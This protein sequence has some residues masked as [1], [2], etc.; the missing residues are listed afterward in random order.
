[1]KNLFV[2]AA[3]ALLMLSAYG[4]KIELIPSENTINMNAG[5]TTQTQLTIK[6]NQDK[7]QEVTLI[8]GGYFTAQFSPQDY[9]ILANSQA[10]TTLYIT[11]PAD[12][13]GEYSLTITAGSPDMADA[14]LTD[15]KTITI[16]TAG[17][18]SE[19]KGIHSLI[20]MGQ[21]VYQ[22][23]MDILR[24]PRQQEKRMHLTLTYD[25]VLSNRESLTLKD[26]DD[27]CMGDTI[28]ITTNPSGN[29]FG[30][31]GPTD[32]PAVRFVKD[33]NKG[34]IP[35][36]TKTTQ[37]F[38]PL[39][40]YMA[41]CPERPYNDP[42]SESYKIA[43]KDQKDY[44]YPSI[45]ELC[46]CYTELSVIC[47]TNCSAGSGKPDDPRKFDS[48][49]VTSSGKFEIDVSCEASCVAYY[50]NGTTIPL[51]LNSGT[52]SAVY[53]QRYYLTGVNDSREPRLSVPTYTHNVV[54]GK[55]ELKAGIENKGEVI[56]YLDKVILNKPDAKI[57]YRPASIMPG[58]KE[59]IIVEAG[60]DAADLT[61]S[62][63]FSTEKTGCLKYKD[64]IQTYSIG[65]CNADKDCDDKNPLTT[66]VCMDIG[67]ETS[68]CVNSKYEEI[69]PTKTYQTYAMD[70][71]G[72]CKNRYY[73]CYLPENRDNADLYAGDKCYNTQ[74]SYYTNSLGRFLLRYDLSALSKGMYINHAVLRLQAKS[75]NKPQTIEVYA[76]KDDWEGKTC[77]S[78]GDIC[79]QPYCAECS[80][81]YDIP[82]QRIS[83]QTV[84][85]TT[86]YS[87]DITDYVKDEYSKGT[88]FVS[89]QIRGVEERDTA[90]RYRNGPCKT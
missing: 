75:V 42:N 16:T 47:E 33:L 17:D 29:A 51:T 89:L 34:I 69:R 26:G 15:T 37:E 76:A 32:D 63:S 12:F 13:S 25:P 45:G 74:N 7:D 57:L 28:N 81:P 85:D 40:L 23:K 68:H 53:T 83:S 46:E 31:G 64:F 2:I 22:P 43:D 79:T 6:N 50:P 71:Q 4:S 8:G 30:D 66:D 77:A 41:H 9:T 11:S 14:S 78:G 82:G 39:C 58:A 56:A 65:A 10:E 21:T 3:V 87:F 80:G 62:I 48:L 49:H 18:G 61:V 1:M 60:T 70:V 38:T 35:G 88:R 90:A 54:N 44:G 19:L 59:D 20:S 52:G 72:S 67:T 5:S 27:V 86:T 36:K 84:G 73:T 24:M 55:T